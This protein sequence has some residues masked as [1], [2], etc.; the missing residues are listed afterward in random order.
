MKKYPLPPFN[1]DT[2]KQKVQ[3]AEDAWNS[4]DPIT[5]SMECP[6]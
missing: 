4:K 3:M 6:Y 5:A 1:E 2:A